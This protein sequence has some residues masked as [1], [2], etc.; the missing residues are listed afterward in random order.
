MNGTKTSIGERKH[1]KK[2]ERYNRM[3]LEFWWQHARHLH[4]NI[5]KMN[6]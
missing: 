4:K 3:L 1:K 6:S 5:D 2:K